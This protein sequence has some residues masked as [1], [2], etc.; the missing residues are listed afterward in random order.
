MRH[1]R[2]RLG[3]EREVFPDQWTVL[4]CGLSRHR[5]DRHGAAGDLY[6]GDLRQSSDVDQPLDVSQAIPKQ[7][8]QASAAG[9]GLRLIAFVG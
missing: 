5:P 4:D 3:Q 9:K 2:H 1:E 7:R 6:P 8:Y